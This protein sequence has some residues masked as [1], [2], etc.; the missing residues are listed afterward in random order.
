MKVKGQTSS[1]ISLFSEDRL[2]PRDGVFGKDE[3]YFSHVFISC[4]SF[5][6]VFNLIDRLVSRFPSFCC[7]CARY[8]IKQCL[9][10]SYV[11]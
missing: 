9:A 10:G 11:A 2:P 6:L 5:Q 3:I 7:I 1:K 8:L 4:L